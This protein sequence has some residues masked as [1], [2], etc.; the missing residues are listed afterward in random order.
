MTSSSDFEHQR[1]LKKFPQELTIPFTVRIIN[2]LEVEW[3]PNLVLEPHVHEYWQLLYVIEGRT[4]I[5]L[6]QR[7]P[8]Y[9]K[10]RN[11]LLVE[12][13]VEHGFAQGSGESCRV[14]DVKY[15]FS[16]PPEFLPVTKGVS[17][18][19]PD[20]F[21]LFRVVDRILEEIAE[22]RKG[23]EAGATFALLTLITYIFR[24]LQEQPGK[25]EQDDMWSDESGAFHYANR[26]AQLALRAKAYIDGHYY[27][28]LGRQEIANRVSV[29]PGYLSR[30]FQ[31]HIGL[32]PI[33][34]LTKV[35]LQKAKSLLG[36]TDMPIHAV[37]SQVGYNNPQYF[38]RIFRK[39]EGMSPMEYRNLRRCQMK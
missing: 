36:E 17:G 11:L 35:R 39:C 10:A 27:E 12:P 26:A 38:A 21:G 31:L 3:Q 33:E 13:G 20:R 37:S 2:L 15:A 9:L 25:S 30:L 14:F 22:R 6:G 28:N 5:R 23:W 8:F 24:V 18:I 4:Q 1:I 34:Y 7:R 16:A 29:S 32:S 19:I